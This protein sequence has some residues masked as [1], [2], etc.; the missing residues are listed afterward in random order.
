MKPQ[1]IILLLLISISGFS[2]K[3]NIVW[4]GIN[5]KEHLKNRQDSTTWD[6]ELM[7]RDVEDSLY[8]CQGRPFPHGAFPVPKYDL[9]GKFRYKGAGIGGNVVEYHDKKIA[10]TF[11]SKGKT[12]TTEN[13]LKDKEDEVYFTFVILTDFVDTVKYSHTSAYFTS[14]NNPDVVC[15][16]FYKTKTEEIDYT[17]FITANRDEFAIVNMRLFNLKSGRIILIAPQKDRTLRSLQLDPPIMSSGEI[18]NYI[19]EILKQN[20]VKAFFDNKDNI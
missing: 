12:I 1:L 20:N 2:Q 6:K 4:S 5:E 19:K 14:R 15:E 7:Q 11:F 9:V 3:R 18:S 16:G 10:Y 13:I 8:N 17:A